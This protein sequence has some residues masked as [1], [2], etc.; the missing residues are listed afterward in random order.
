MINK[1]EKDYFFLSNFWPCF[2]LGRSVEH[3]YQAAKATNLKDRNWVLDS[4][5][6]GEAKY[7][8]RR[9]EV[10]KGW[11][12]IKLYRMEEL[13][14]RKFFDPELKSWLLATKDAELIEGNWW[15]DTF[16]GVCKG[17]G[18]NHLGKL[19][20][21]IRKEFNGELAEREGVRL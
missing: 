3:Y 4:R 7:R 14:R 19:L 18:E 17:I 6:A 2:E 13:L 12:E 15:G 21:K 1:F 16:W 11:D 10:I 5:S 20:M 8:G 9:I